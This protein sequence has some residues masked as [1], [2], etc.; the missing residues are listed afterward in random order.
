MRHGKGE[1][2]DVKKDQLLS[3]EVNFMRKCFTCT[4]SP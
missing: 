4:Q 1:D 3:T 2:M